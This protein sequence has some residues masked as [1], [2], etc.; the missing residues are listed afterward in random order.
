TFSGE[1]VT[2]TLA[3]VIRAEPDWSQLPAATPARVRVLLQRC[4]QKDAK[5]RLQ[6][7]GDARISLEEVLSGVPEPTSLAGAAAPASAPPSRRALPWAVAACLAVALAALGWAYAHNVSAPAPA[8]LTR[9]EIPVP[10]KVTLASDDAFALSPDG[11]QL[12]FFSTGADGVQR[13]WVRAL[14]SLQAHSLPGSE[15]TVTVPSL[16]WSPDSRRIAFSTAGMLKTID[17]SNGT[18]ETLC[19]TSALVV[20]GSWNRDGVIIFGQYP[21]GGLMRVPAN[22]GPASQLTAPDPSREADVFPSF[23]PDGRHFIYL[24]A[25]INRANSGVYIGSL[26]AKPAEQS[27]KRLVATTYGPVYVPF[28]GPG[29]GQLMFMTQDRTLM[30]QPFDARR[31][32]LTGEPVP[33]AEQIGSFLSS[34]LFSASANGVL[35]YKTD[36]GGVSRLTWFDQ[37]GKVLGT[38]GEPGVYDTISLSPNGTQAVVSRADDPLDTRVETL[39]LV[40]FS[41]GTSTRFTFGSSSATLGA[42]SPHGNRII[43][44]SNR[45]GEYDLYQ[46][47]ASGVTPEEV[48]LKSSDDKWLNSWSHDGHFLLYQSTGESTKATKEDLWVLP[49][50]G[51]KKPFLFESTGPNNDDGQFSPDGH[52]IAYV[53]NESGRDEIYVRTFSPATT[54]IAA[55]T[56]GKWLISTAGGTEPRWRGDGKELYYLAPD[57][58]L[59]A[60]DISD[61][62]EFRA[63]EPKPLFQAPRHLAYVS[64]NHWDVTR[65]GK[66]FLFAAQ[67]TE[68]PFTVVLNWQAALRPSAKN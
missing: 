18:T 13:I 47:L 32:D 65:D 30:A 49:L 23:L 20:G 3:A 10:R 4:L 66:R 48:L 34:G 21:S 27:S 6:A 68:A 60:V 39:W 58:M 24:R 8:E 40:D 31:L 35:A 11:R 9:F 12:A 1:T 43:F 55:A 15:S 41:R 37:Q 59:M 19:D 14:D 57:D 62:P 25:S 33:V 7:I 67:S 22:G 38:A 52:L 56:G 17:I 2:D 63:G 28:S 42:W 45:S 50:E 5:Q 44:S 64:E 26:D 53:S 54:V 16:F 36:V 29:F 61:S 51:D 46:K